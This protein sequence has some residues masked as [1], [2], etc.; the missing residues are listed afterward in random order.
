MGVKMKPDIRFAA[1]CSAE[2]HRHCSFY[3]PEARCSPGSVMTTGF[4]GV[5]WNRP[6]VCQ[7]RSHT[8]AWMN[9]EQA[10]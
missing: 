7:D 9:L 6:E 5:C 10:M 4:I 8:T 2:L 1:H 3:T